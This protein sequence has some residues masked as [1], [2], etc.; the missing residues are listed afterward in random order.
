MGTAVSTT[1][2][3]SKSRRALLAGA[4]GGLG[5]WAASAVGRASRVRAA[6]GET[7]LV[8]GEY[9]SSSVTKISNLSNNGVVLEGISSSGTGVVG[10]SSSFYGVQAISNTGSGVGA[11]STSGV[12]VYGASQSH[13][14]VWGFSDAGTGLFGSC[15][16]GLALRAEGRIK[17]STSGV[18]TIPA[19]SSSRTVTPGVNVT[20]GSFVLLTPK[21]NI[22]S[23]ALWFTTNATTDKFTI[24][25]N[26]PRSSGTKVAWLLV[27]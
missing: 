23:R 17:F 24:R 10:V 11:F 26:S 5:A 1:P 16:T 2:A 25:M 9:Q 13:R 20:S 18:V 6:D 27:G 14:G 8:G 15:S 3:Q 19:G 22:G 12:G 4:L 21:V 7:V